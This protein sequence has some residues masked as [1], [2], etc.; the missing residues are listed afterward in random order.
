MSPDVL[1]TLRE[2][3]GLTLTQAAALLASEHGGQAETWR[4]KLTRY[5]RGQATPAPGRAA[6]I[7]RTYEA[8]DVEDAVGDVMAALGGSRGV[9]ELEKDHGREVVAMALERVAAEV[10]T[11]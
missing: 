8:H 7:M 9:A 2:V 5:E 1:R 4:V 10:R 6:L 11:K 3:R